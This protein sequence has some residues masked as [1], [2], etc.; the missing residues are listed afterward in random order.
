MSNHNDFA[1]RT[2]E[3]IEKYG[4]IQRGKFELKSGVKSDFFINF[5][6]LLGNS[7]TLS[8][9]GR[10]FSEFLIENW[11]LNEVDVLFGSAYKGIPLVTACALNLNRSG[12]DIEIA[13]D[14]KEVKEH[15]EGGLIIGPSLEGKRVL[16]LD[17]VFTT[18]K[19]FK[20]NAEKIKNAGGI[21]CG[22]VV[23]VDRSENIT[24]MEEVKEKYSINVISLLKI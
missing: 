14:R 22:L 21:L 2:K 3:L 5:G 13:Y 7:E 15:G 6:V 20:L 17:D 4:A 23:G 19:A 1:S 10:L 16:I 9:V 24:F 8:E 18:G 11:D 12:I